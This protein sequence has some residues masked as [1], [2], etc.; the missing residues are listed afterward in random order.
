NE[1]CKRAFHAHPI[2]A[3]PPPPVAVEKGENHCLGFSILGIEDKSSFV[4]KNDEEHKNEVEVIEISN[5]ETEDG[6]GGKEEFLGV[7][8][9]SVETDGGQVNKDSDN[10]EGCAEMVAEGENIGVEGNGRKEESLGIEEKLV[11]IDGCQVNKESDKND[12]VGTKIVSD[13]GTKGKN[14]DAEIRNEKNDE[15]YVAT[16][17]D[18]IMDLQESVDLEFEFHGECVFF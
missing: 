4:R 18:I 11:E 1:N 9:K 5:D 7:E 17:D 16:E 13:E 10:D 15:Y 8:E 6:N 12:E 3:P 2:V 14:V